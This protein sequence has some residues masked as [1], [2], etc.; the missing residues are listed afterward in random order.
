MQNH[1]HF[2]S[3]KATHFLRP[4]SSAPRHWRFAGGPQ[5]TPASAIFWDGPAPPPPLPFPLPQ[6]DLSSTAPVRPALTRPKIGAEE[7]P[8]LT[9]LVSRPASR[10]KRASGL[11]EISGCL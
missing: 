1:Q 11:P 4:L 7:L 10:G 8:V 2:L 9:G 6:L 5:L 3:P